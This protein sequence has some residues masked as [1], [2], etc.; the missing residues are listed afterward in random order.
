MNRAGLFGKTSGQASANF[1]TTHVLIGGPNWYLDG[2]CV[3]DGGNLIQQFEYSGN[4]KLLVGNGQ[5]TWN[6]WV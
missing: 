5:R 1:A 2:G 6:H 3:S 4:N